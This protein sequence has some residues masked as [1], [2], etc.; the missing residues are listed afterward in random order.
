MLSNVA[1]SFGGCTNPVIGMCQGYKRNCGKFYCATHGGWSSLCHDCSQ[2]KIA[3]EIKQDYETTLINLKKEV[4]KKAKFNEV[5]ISTI[6]V[7][8]LG[9]MINSVM[10]QQE[11]NMLVG[12]VGIIAWG[13]AIYFIINYQKSKKRIWEASIA[14]LVA[15]K[16]GFNEFYNTWKQVE[17]QKSAER[18]K[19]IALGVAATILAAAVAGVA[20]DAQSSSDQAKVQRAVDDE[21]RR[22]GL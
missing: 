12:G 3:D 4:R 1:C 13:A 18:K 9:A 17:D 8:V 22:R 5:V 16:P 19:Q 21:M 20:Q 10:L 6:A 15:T 2:E 14:D 7:L 11:G